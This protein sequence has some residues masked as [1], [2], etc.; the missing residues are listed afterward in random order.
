MLID[1]T[2]LSLRSL[3]LTRANLIEPNENFYQETARWAE[4]LYEHAPK[5]H[6]MVWVSRQFDTSKSILLFGDRVDASWL[7]DL[8]SAEALDRG[9]GFKRVLEAATQAGIT[10]VEG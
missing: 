6:G 5:A 7:T 10:V 9:R 3:G 2:G 4:A 1:L 8:S